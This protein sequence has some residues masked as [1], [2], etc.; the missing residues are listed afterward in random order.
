MPRF[1]QNAAALRP[2]PRHAET[3]AAHLDSVVMHRSLVR[4][5]A[6]H[7][8]VFRAPDTSFA[9]KGDEVLEAA[10]LA[11][12]AHAAV[13]EQAAAQ[14]FLDLAHHEARQSASLM[15]ALF[16]LAPVRCDGAVEHRL[17]GPMALVGAAGGRGAARGV[18][19]HGGTTRGSSVP[20]GDA[21]ICGRSRTHGWRTWPAGWRPPA[22]RSH[23]A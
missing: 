8:D 13:F 14:V 10:S 15:S 21:A 19:R 22:A 4:S 12:D 6:P 9:R 16:E 20:L 1:A 23:A 11:A 7:Q 3:W 5:D 17:F 2:L 18:L